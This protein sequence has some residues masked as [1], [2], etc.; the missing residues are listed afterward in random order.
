MRVVR[1]GV[2]LFV[3]GL[4]FILIDVLPYFLGAHDRPLWLNLACLLAPIGFVVAV[5][6]TLRRGRE[7]Q[8]RAVAELDRANAG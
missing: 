1:I 8:R 7:E 3:L 6:P 4:V 2:G 5:W